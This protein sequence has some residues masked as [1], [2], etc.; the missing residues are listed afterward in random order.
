MAGRARAKDGAAGNRLVRVRHGWLAGLGPGAGKRA[1]MISSF[2]FFDGCFGRL[3]HVLWAGLAVAFASHRAA[4][5]ASDGQVGGKDSR[6]R[7]S[8]SRSG[9]APQEPRGRGGRMRRVQTRPHG[10]RVHVPS[11]MDEQ[12]CVLYSINRWPSVCRCSRQQLSST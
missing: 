5:M 3:A 6:S 4:G 2:F 1:A 7:S 11:G 10:K 12:E 8:R 9:L